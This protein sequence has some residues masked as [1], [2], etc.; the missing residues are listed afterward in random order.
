MNITRENKNEVN[1]TLKILVEKPDYEKAVEDSLKDFRKKANIPGFRPGKVPAGLVKK[2]FGK[3]ILVEEVNK[4]LSENLSK[5]IVEEKLQLLGEP[6]PNEAEQK[7]I[8]WDADES[9]EFA[10]DVA[11]A[12][13]VKV[14]LDKNM[15]LP[16]YKIKVSKEMI[17][18]QIDRI[19][20]QTG[21]NIPADDVKEK[22]LVRGDFVQLDENGEEVENG[23]RPE[24]ILVSVDLIKDE[25]I[26]KE[27]I[28][29]KKDD[30]IIFDPVKA[31]NN[32]HEVGHMLN[33]SHE[34]AETLDSNFKF[35]IK[36]ILE[37]RKAELN[38]ELFKKMYGEESEIKTEEDLR[39]KVKEEIAENL[40]F[41]SDHK[42][43]I[44]ARDFLLE[45]TDVELPE[46]FLKRWLL[47]V[48]KELTEEQIEN[49]FDGF[50]KDL[51]W[52]LIKDAIAK[53][54]DL[55][56]EPDEAADYAKQVARAQYNQYGI[57]DV[58]DEQLESYAK[59]IM[60]KPEER[61]NIYKKLQEE[62]VINVVKENVKIDEKEVT[63]DEFNEFWK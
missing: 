52:Q 32:R 47:K 54:N 23:I 26:K 3:G 43:T 31:Y 5:Y 13:D 61:E 49:E 56:V 7:D 27:F 16:Y 53:D 21:K 39:N 58:P 11:L 15:E 33:I 40:A 35:T 22:G 30:V 59:M 51:K 25:E 18:E 50:T 38:E 48:N 28:G 36:E 62:K 9:F 63:R 14:L 60:E 45:K 19:Q 55:K 20:T 24:G 4:I 17:D 29:K 42:F 57:F 34:D 8:D 2:R 44:D 6:L 46:E 1:A 37:F 10:F 12:P 41:S